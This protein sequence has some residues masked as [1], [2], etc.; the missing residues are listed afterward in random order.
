M[1]R[2]KLRTL[3]CKPPVNCSVTHK[4]LDNKNN[5]TCYDCY[6]FVIK[7]L[8]EIAETRINTGFF[9]QLDLFPFDGRRRLGG[10]I[11]DDA[12]DLAAFVGDARGDRG[13]HIV[14]DTGPVGGH[15]VFRADR[16]QDDRRAVGALVALDADRVNVSQK[17][18]RALPDV[19][20]ETGLGEFLAG[21]GVG[22]A[23]Q[24]EALLGDLADDADAQT[25]AREGLTPDDFVGQTELGADGAHLILEQSAQ[26]FD[27]LELDVLGQAADVVVALDGDGFFA[28]GAARLDHVGVDGA[29]GQEGGALVAGIGGFQLG[30]LG[31]EHVHE[32]AANDLALLLGFAHAGELAQEQVAGVH[33][34]HLGVQL[35]LEHVHDH[36]AF[37]KAQQAVVNEHAGQLVADGAVDER[38]GH[39]GIDAAGQAKNHFLVAHLLADLGNRF[40]DVILHHPVGLRAADV[41][42]EAREQRHALHGVRDLGVELHGVIAP[43]LVGHAGD[44]AA[45]RAG[46]E[47]EA[48]RQRR[49]LV[50]VAH[51]HLEHAVAFGGGEVLDAFE[52]RG[53]AVS[54]HLGVAKLA[55]VAAF[56]LAAQLVGHGLHAVADAQHRDAQ[57][58]HGVRRLVVHFVDA[59]V[60]ARQDHALEPAVGGKFAHPVAAHVA[61]VHL[62]VHM[63][64]AHAARDELGDLGAEVEDEDLVVCHGDL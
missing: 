23:Q 10:A 53:V 58:E 3:V 38:G 56:N 36:V 30:R 9:K 35:A 19:A 49:D 7:R 27:E 61:G 52:Q 21:D 5:G 37:M 62:A 54:A 25:R 12:V 34:D 57:L 4:P 63:R 29:L 2:A 46:H 51:P 16:A 22:L 40:F 42:H 28:L 45:G 43:R 6:Q 17:H 48:R 15:G 1:F 44:G 26:R 47:L 55:A 20:V 18:D 11:E 8:I 31:L 50:A 60:T 33:T 39:A 64:L 41:P 24:V 32:Q 13:E 59:G 14:G